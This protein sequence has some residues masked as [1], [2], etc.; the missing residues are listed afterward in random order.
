LLIAMALQLSADL[1]ISLGTLV[2]VLLAYVAV[3]ASRG[4]AV[5]STAS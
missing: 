3:R 2:V 4:S 1:F 5:G